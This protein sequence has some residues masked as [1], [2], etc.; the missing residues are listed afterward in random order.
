MKQSVLLLFV[1][2]W[3]CVCPISNINAQ[4]VGINPAGNAPNSSAGLDVS[5]N[6]KGALIP[7]LTTVQMDAI[8]SPAVGLL[9]YNTDCNTINYY[10]GGSWIAV[11]N[12]SGIGTPG[13]ISGI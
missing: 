3:L 13:T 2:I 6:N 10:N 7:R 8:T 12:V 9:V 11:G 4:G 1:F 5:F